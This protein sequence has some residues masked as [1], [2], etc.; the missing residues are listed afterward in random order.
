MQ[1]IVQY[2]LKTTLKIFSAKKIVYKQN[3]F[4]STNKC[5]TISKKIAAMLSFKNPNIQYCI[6]YL[7]HSH[8]AYEIYIFLIDQK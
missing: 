4:L 6:A 1:I 5:F 2:I 8:I 7:F 3:V